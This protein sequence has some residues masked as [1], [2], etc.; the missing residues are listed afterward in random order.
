MTDLNAV[1]TLDQ[2]TLQGRSDGGVTAFL[3]VPFAAAPIGGLRFAPP[4]PPTPWQ[5]VR[6]ATTC[7]PAAPQP[8][9]DPDRP[10]DAMQLLT[11]SPSLLQAEDNCLTLNVWTP[12]L[13]GAPRAVLVWIHGSGWLSGATAWPGYHGRNLAAAEDIVVVTPNYRLGPLG[14]LRVPGV[15]EGNMGFLDAVAALRWVH[16]NIARFGGDPG[17]VTVAGQSGGA[18][19]SVALLTSPLA[20]G[21][22]RRV[23]AQSGPLGIPMPTPDEAEQ[24]GKE[25]LNVLGLTPATA[26]RLRDLPAG[27]LIDGYRSLV[28]GGGRRRIG[29]PAPP[30]HPIAGGPGLPT[31]VLEALDGGAGAGIDVLIGA[32]AE[33]MNPFLAIDPSAAA[34]TRDAV[35]QLLAK[36]APGTDADTVYGHYET[37]RPGARPSQILADITTDRLVRLPALRVAEARARHG[38][39]GYVYQ[40]DWRSPALGACHTVDI[41]LLFDNLPAWSASPMFAGV[42]PAAVEPIGRPF[43]RAVGS[44]VRTG[45]PNAP[46]VPEWAAYTPA[47]RRTLRFDTLTTALSDP[48]GGERRLLSAHRT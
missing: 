15:A 42:D 19:T 16:E 25:Y 1:V 47:D 48:A 26:H 8:P 6:Q 24:T 35:L 7:G 41:P 22:F 29:A 44:F 9:A 46:G 28:A 11:G 10:A 4:Q 2:G 21:L 30:M 43:R 32:T 23:F 12:G 17:R 40:V 34:I 31:P 33:E 14:F 39:P 5:G 36:L 20:T 3:G 13:T 18:V 45:D 27:R 38:H 37:R